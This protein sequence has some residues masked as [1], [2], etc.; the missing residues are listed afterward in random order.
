MGQTKLNLKVVN[1]KLIIT[2]M[3]NLIIRLILSKD[4]LINLEIKPDKV[5]VTLVK[6]NQ[7]FLVGL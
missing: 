7:L 6:L 3:A 4:N 1:T 2:Y 5:I